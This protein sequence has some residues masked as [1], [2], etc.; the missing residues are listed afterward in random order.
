MENFYENNLVYLV[1][2][3]HYSPLTGTSEHLM[4]IR[5]TIEGANQYVEAINVLYPLDVTR[6]D[7]VYVD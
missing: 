1:W 4:G 6:V 5:S 2:R 3:I 7:A